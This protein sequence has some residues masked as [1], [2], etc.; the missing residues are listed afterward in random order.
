M[1]KTRTVQKIPFLGPDVETKIIPSPTDGWDAISPLAEM[2]PKRAPILKNW[3]PRP[4]YVEVRQGYF[5]W[6]PTNS[7]PVE[8]L[9]IYRNP[10]GE[11]MFAAA[12]SEI[13]DASNYGLPVAVVTGLGSARWQ[14]INFTPSGAATVLQ[15][16]N[17]V[18]QLRQ[19]N[20]TSWST[21]SITGLPPGVGSTADIINI[22]AQKARLWYI[23]KN[24]TIVGFLPAE[25]IQG[26]L[27][28]YQDFGSLFYKGGY[29]VAMADW[30]VD[31]GNGP[32]DYAVFL[33]SK[34]QIAIYAGTDPTNPNAWSLVGVFNL[35]PP[36]GLRCA[37]GIG[38][39]VALITQ[40]GV[41]PISQALP[42]DPSADR[43]VAITARIQNAMAQAAQIGSNLFG[44][45]LMAYPLQTLLFLNVPISENEEQQ[46]FVMNTLTGAWCQFIG[47]NANCFEV[48]YN[49][50]YF[51]DNNGSVNQAYTGY[52][53]GTSSISIDM[54]C[55]FNWFDE[56]GKVKRM[57]MI[58]PLLTTQGNVVPALSV[59]TDFGTSTAVNPLVIT[60]GGAVWD[61]AIWDKSTW[62]SG[63]T[64]YIQWLTV[65]AIG[66]AFAARINTVLVYNAGAG[67]LFDSAVFD[68]A[69]FDG[70]PNGEAV[71]LQV[72]VFN[73]ILE[74]G[75]AI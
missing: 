64:N 60:Q 5:Q 73:A 23:F 72:N 45:Q 42:F 74:T 31:G 25:D 69:T 20:G 10:N 37:Y 56:P 8:T 12:G 29:L 46:Q 3:V 13:F 26:A 2:D 38:S 18:D 19:W 47:W 55:A 66:H 11:T 44:W 71:T 49:T 75:G 63:A 41:I 27:A 50:L 32:Q 48:F 16:C 58:Q 61:T 54:Q 9:M 57:T 15:C 70:S 40:Q 17:G 65:E 67:S 39:D 28:G 6:V 53:D 4:G 35:S 59:D 51:G 62:P 36:M 24:S 14:Y 30:T 68:S 7:N 22:Y 33:S 21:P 52:A 1:R 43:S 34:G